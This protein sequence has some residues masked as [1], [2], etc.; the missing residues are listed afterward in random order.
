MT[1]PTQK[2]ETVATDAGNAD[3]VAKAAGAVAAAPKEPKAKRADKA[4]AP[5]TT[6]VVTGPEKGR[7]R[8]GRKFTREPSSIPLGDLKEGDLEK[9]QADPELFVQVID[10]PH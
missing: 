7:W 2:P 6:V 9:L 5:E 1:D 3:A 10:A 8:A 4:E